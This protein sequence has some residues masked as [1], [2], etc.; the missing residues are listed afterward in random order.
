VLAKDGDDSS[1]DTTPLHL[2]RDDVRDFMCSLSM[3]S[4]RERDLMQWHAR[5]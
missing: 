2:A 3:S 4:D 1:R 5:N